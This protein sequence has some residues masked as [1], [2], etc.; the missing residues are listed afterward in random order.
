MKLDLNKLYMTSGDLKDVIFIM[1]LASCIIVYTICR[2]ILI[3][4]EIKNMDC[5]CDSCKTKPK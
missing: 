4:T 5:E 1:C 2:A 3:R